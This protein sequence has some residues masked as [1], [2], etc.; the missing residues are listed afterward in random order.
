ML[1]I[2]KSNSGF[3]PRWIEYC[4]QKN[5]SYKIVDCYD[6]DIIEQ[7]ENCNALMWHFHQNNPKDI[8][9]AKL[10]L[11]SLQ[12]SGKKVFPDFNTMWHFDDKLGQKYLLELI[13]APFV[14]TYVFYEKTKA[15]EWVKQTDFPKV[16]KLRG[17]AGSANVKLVENKTEAVKIINKAFGKG[18]KNYDAIGSVKERWRKYKLNKTNLWDVTKGIIRLGYE[19]EFSKLMSRERGYVYFQDFIPY[20]KFDIRIIVID[21]KAFALKRMVRENDFRA[22]GSGEFKYAREEFDERCIKIAFE[23]SKKLKAQ[24]LAYDFVFDEKNNPLIVEISYGFTPEGYDAC[25]GYWDEEI[26]WNEG[27]FNPYGWMVELVLNN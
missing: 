8:L 25:P 19:P 9:F 1:A 12:Q 20:N 26:N 27:K 24:C 4:K 10:L 16:F 6:N 7:L 22:S 23:T 14:P 13:D 3:H 11:F 17:G 21:N 15:L 5:I 18:F 2:H